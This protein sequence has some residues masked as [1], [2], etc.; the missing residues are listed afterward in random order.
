MKCSECGTEMSPPVT[1]SAPY[2]CGIPV[3]L[4]GVTIHACPSC[5]EKEVEVPGLASLHDALARVV[6]QKPGRLNGDEIRFLRKHLGWSGKDFA[7]HFDISPQQVSYWENDKRPMGKN[8]EKLLRMRA[9]LPVGEGDYSSPEE[10][11]G[12]LGADE[13][14]SL[15]Q[16]AV[17]VLDQPVSS[18]M[19]RPRRP[20]ENRVSF[21]E[22]RWMPSGPVGGAGGALV[23]C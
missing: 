17:A 5:G 13:L 8:A 10:S 6:A 15:I 7:R 1:G 19:P 21:H 12:A 4:D 3:I 18:E 23:P 16:R 9:L 11:A 22:S 20:V 14:R 2:P